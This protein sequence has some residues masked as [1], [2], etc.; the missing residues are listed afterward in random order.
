MK[1]EEKTKEQLLEELNALRMEFAGLKELERK[2]KERTASLETANKELE[3][4]SYSVSHDL[5]APLR[6]IIGFSQALIEDYAD[7]LDSEGLDY[8][9]R[10][11]NGARRM[12]ELIE[13]ILQLSRISRATM[14]HETV[15][16]SAIARIVAVELR[17]KEPDREVMFTIAPGLS[18]SGDS[19]LIRVMLENLL[20]NAWKFTSKKSG[21][22]IK[23][24]MLERP[25]KET[26]ETGAKPA[27]Y[28]QDNGAG[29]DMCCVENLFGAFQRF[30]RA[31][32]FPGTGIGLATVQ[33]II[34]R[35]GGRVWAEGKVDEGAVFYFTLTHEQ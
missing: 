22:A 23:F 7:K 10:V 29:F 17:K 32:E 3:S 19:R 31:D 16:L 5:R 8:L 14:K 15:D 27:F 20:G 18:A 30:H 12:G 6:A 28:I 2:V 13:D 24:D 33:R 11:H 25:G 35:H 34:H 26:G 4:F 21:A 1:D 9:R